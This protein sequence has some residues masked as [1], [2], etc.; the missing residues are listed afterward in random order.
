MPRSRMTHSIK[1]IR[2][3]AQQCY[4]IQ[5]TS[6]G[7]AR[8][9]RAASNRS[10]GQHVA[11]NPTEHKRTLN[12]NHSTEL[13]VQLFTDYASKCPKVDFFWLFLGG[14][15]VWFDFI[16]HMIWCLK[17]SC[18][19]CAYKEKTKRSYSERAAASDDLLIDLMDDTMGNTDSAHSTECCSSSADSNYLDSSPGPALRQTTK[20]K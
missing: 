1:E 12:P 7:I 10:A 18:S 6:V 2:K 15:S 16:I 19:K 4:A 8:S 17:S 5:D 13:R 9:E 11:P 3:G 20:R 14:C